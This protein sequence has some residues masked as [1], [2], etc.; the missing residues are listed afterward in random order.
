MPGISSSVGLVSGIDSKAIIDQLMALE[1]LPKTKLQARMA[2]ETAKKT[3]FTTLQAQVTSLRLFGTTMKKP[4]T[5]RNATVKSGDENVLTG[6]ASAGAAAGSYQVSVARLVSSQQTIGKGYA[7]TDSTRVGAGTLTF[8]LGGGALDEPTELDDL[9]GGKGVGR[10]KFRLTDRSGASTIVDV[11]DAMTLND[12]VDKINTSLDVS[13]R[14]SI[15]DNALTLTD[16]TGQTTSG[17]IVT[18]IGTGTAAADL[19]I[20]GITNAATKTGA[21]LNGLRSDTALSALYDGRGLRTAGGSLADFSV[22]TA[23]GATTQVKLGGATTL[24]DVVSAINTQLNGKAIASLGS[25]GL[26][27][28]D[29][30]ADYGDPANP[31]AAPIT[32]AAL[33]NSQ[34]L[35]DLG[36]SG[37]TASATGGITGNA[38]ASGINTTMVSSLRGGKGLDLGTIRIKNRAGTT[39]DINLSGA[40]TVDEIL[41][42]INDAGAN[43]KAAVKSGGNS[44]TLTDLDDAGGTL[45]VSDVSGTAAAELGLA[46]S[47]AAT[48]GGAAI[49]GANLQKAWFNRKTVLKDLNGGKGVPDGKFTLVDSA[50]K[51]ITV[52]VDATKDSTVGDI[53]DKIN[54]SSTFGAKA[55]INDN[56]DGLLLTD[57]AGGTSKLKVEEV[58]SGSTAKSLNLLGT[59]TAT[60]IDGSWEKTITV[61]PTDTLDSVQKAIQTLSWGLSATIVNDGSDASPYRL[62]LTS[63]NSGKSGRVVFDSGAVNLGERTL[64]AAQDAAVFIGGDAGT[65]PILVRA[66]SNEVSGA[67]RGVTLSLTGVSDKPVTLNVARNVDNIVTAAGSFVEGFNTLVTALKDYTKFD[68]ST[69]TRGD[70]LGDPAAQSVENEIYGMINTVGSTSGKYRIAADVGFT[71]GADGALAF[72]EDK[73]RTAFADDPDAVTSLFTRAGSA[74]TDDTALGGLRTGQGIRSVAGNDFRVLAKDGTTFD[75]DVTD[76]TSVG[77]VIKQINDAAGNNGKVTASVNSAGTGIDLVDASTSG[78][79]KFTVS[80][81]NGSIAASDLGLLQTA[82]SGRISGRALIDVNSGNDGGIGTILEKRLNRLID[83]VNGTLTRASKQVD[84]RNDEFQ[85]RINTLDT[86][87]ATKKGRLE[88]QFSGLE[89][90]LS[91][92]QGQQTALNSFSSA[93]TG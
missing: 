25:N 69:N 20:D 62:S 57:T 6:T 37:K 68:T 90:S 24:G 50:G 23:D 32:F 8:E 30:S 41:G 88:K 19:G 70:L 89:S 26:S 18:D 39:R 61:K 17:L 60:T 4:Q 10:G 15:K 66:S 83:P 49:S 77:D 74:L 7:D 71:I 1:T 76:L 65:S 64:V 55:S 56:G 58:N 92:L 84:T 43:V 53:I 31:V 16:Q 44:I 93:S 47:F 79:K 45:V 11:G 67:I 28:V 27:I 87:L 36:L 51:S 91:N 38:F 63:T 46:G 29:K 22:K 14:A 73:F 33:N 85:D 40:S 2:T 80:T 35:D 13:V 81:L 3:A 9:N 52:T 12:V 59:A 42:R 86:L 54:A 78:T 82:S 48:S 75:V 72:D 21:A 5:F 34:A